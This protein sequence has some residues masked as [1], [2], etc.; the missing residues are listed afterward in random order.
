VTQRT[1][2]AELTSVGVIDAM[3]VDAVLT[4]LAEVMR[5]V[6]VFT[7]RKL[8]EAQQRKARQVVFERARLAPGLGR[9]T[10][11]AATS[12][13]SSVNVD[14][15]VAVHAEFGCCRILD[16]GGVTQLAVEV[17]V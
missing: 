14:A 16:R 12:L 6:T 3:A 8:V 17:R 9:V 1:T 13:G 2:F 4:R 7:S 11:L 10:F 15:S 5:Y